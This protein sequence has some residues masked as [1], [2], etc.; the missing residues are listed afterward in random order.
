[1]NLTMPRETVEFVALTMS[2]G[3]GP[4]TDFEVAVTV[5]GQRPATW[6][7]NVSH[8]GDNGVIIN[9][10]TLGGPGRFVIW[11]R[12]AAP[13]ETPVVELGVITLT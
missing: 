8:A 7:A 10:P 11:G 5:Y 12:I 4:R 3:D 6:S 13:P 1:M 9:G 2:D